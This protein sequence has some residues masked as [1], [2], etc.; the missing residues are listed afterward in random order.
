MKNLLFVMEK[1][2]NKPVTVNPKEIENADDFKELVESLNGEAN[3]EKGIEYL[4]KK[5]YGGEIIIEKD[6]LGWYFMVPSKEEQ[7]K[8]LLN[9]F[10][11]IENVVQSLKKETSCSFE[12]KSESFRKLHCLAEFLDDV[13]L[14][15][16]SESF[17]LCYKDFIAHG[18]CGVKYYLHKAYYYTPV[19]DLDGLL[20][21]ENLARFNNFIEAQEDKRLQETLKYGAWEK[22]LL[23]NTPVIMCGTQSTYTD[24]IESTIFKALKNM[25]EFFEISKLP[26]C[27]VKEIGASASLESLNCELS[28]EIRDKILDEYEKMGIHF[29]AMIDD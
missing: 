5:N 13:L 2:E 29:A 9:T 14:Y 16:S 21:D 28:T 6:D 23:K 27:G 4:K 18:E 25:N 26:D 10:D 17:G 15:Q 3:L 8:I 12:Y 7:K 20:K 1:A 19:M 24:I 22:I 11:K